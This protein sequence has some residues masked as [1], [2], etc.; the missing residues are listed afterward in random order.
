M[1]KLAEKFLTDLGLDRMTD[2]FW[3]NSIFEKPK[4]GRNIVW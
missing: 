3:Q 1:F 2:K 4:D